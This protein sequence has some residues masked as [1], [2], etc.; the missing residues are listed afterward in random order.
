MENVINNIMKEQLL[1]QY[2]QAVKNNDFIRAGKIKAELKQKFNI[3]DK[4]IKESNDLGFLKDM[5]GMS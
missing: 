2:R 4:E 3:S 5:F 1:K